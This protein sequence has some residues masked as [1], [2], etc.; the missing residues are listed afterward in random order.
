M[1]PSALKHEKNLVPMFDPKIAIH[2]SHGKITWM[3]RRFTS[4]SFLDVVFAVYLCPTRNT[5]FLQLCKGLHHIEASCWK[6]CAMC[7]Y[8][9]WMVKHKHISCR[10]WPKLP[11]RANT[12]HSSLAS[13][14][15]A[16]N[17]KNSSY[18]RVKQLEKILTK[19][20]PT[21]RVHRH[22]NNVGLSNCLTHFIISDLLISICHELLR[23]SNK[24]L[25][26]T[27]KCFWWMFRTTSTISSTTFSSCRSIT[28][29][30]RWCL[31]SSTSS[32]WQCDHSFRHPTW[33]FSCFHKFFDRNQ[34]LPVFRVSYTSS[35]LAHHRK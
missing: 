28:L 23:M 30:C 2:G 29:W 32:C 12:M 20:W 3:Q 1:L 14:T 15:Q 10:G 24:K 4:V 27:K 33:Q 18:D 35:T 11:P 19:N 6:Q 13:L 16:Q 34:M 5:L 26:C 21:Q 31:N 22:S 17:W 9:M 25:H 8:D 7:K